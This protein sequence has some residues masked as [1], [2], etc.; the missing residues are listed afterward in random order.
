MFERLLSLPI[1]KNESACIFGPRGTGKTKWLMTNLKEHEY[2]YL[3]LL[4]ASVYRQL[5][6]NP[7]KLGEFLTT[8]KS[9]WTVIDE[10]QKTPE[11][12]A[13]L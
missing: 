13:G 2:T 10:V 5:K 7:E 12:L 11:I 1:N 6:G 4:D 3:D 9:S 8:D